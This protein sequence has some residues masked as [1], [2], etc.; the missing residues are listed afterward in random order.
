MASD[1]LD[2]PPVRLLPEEELARLALAV[3]LLDR[4]VRLARWSAPHVTVDAMGELTA[5]DATRA[6]RE[7]GLEG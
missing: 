5:E 4:A 1:R 7:L 3:P 6:V 2:L